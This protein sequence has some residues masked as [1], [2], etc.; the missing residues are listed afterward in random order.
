MC[1]LDELVDKGLP[2]QLVAS[3]DLHIYALFTQSES[4]AL[5]QAAVYGLSVIVS[6]HPSITHKLDDCINLIIPA[7]S[8][9]NVAHR[10][11]RDNAVSGL[12]RILVARAP[13]MSETTYET[14]FGL[15]WNHI[16]LLHDDIEATP[17][18]KQLVEL[19]NRFVLQDSA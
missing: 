14:V 18:C 9:V 7:V 6:M 19:L 15:Y 1:I 4:P 3:V 2:S 11:V 10:F 8:R 17:V 13:E 16:P 12:G 5:C